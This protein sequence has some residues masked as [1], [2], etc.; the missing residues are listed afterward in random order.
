MSTRSAVGFSAGDIGFDIKYVHS[1]GYPAGV[2]W[3]IWRHY[4]EGWTIER[5]RTFLFEDHWASF[6]ALSGTDWSKTCGFRDITKRDLDWKNEAAV[7]EYYS[8][9]ACYCHGDRTENADKSEDHVMK[10]RWTGPETPNTF[11]LAGGENITGMEYI[12]VITKT[13]L[14]SM[15]V[16]DQ[17]WNTPEGEKQ[18]MTLTKGVMTPWTLREAK[19]QPYWESVDKQLSAEYEASRKVVIS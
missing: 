10:Y 12:Y 9:P 19:D 17:P 3:T 8:Y 4:N 6:S 13:G 11:E 5:M 14:M 15:A 18:T 7:K 16:V 2:G 1:D